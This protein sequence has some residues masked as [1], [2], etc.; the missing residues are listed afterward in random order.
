M[1]NQTWILEDL[2]I[3]Q[4][5]QKK[6]LYVGHV[7][8]QNGVKMELS[9]KLDAETCTK[10]ITILQEEIVASAVN[11]GDMLMKS[12]PIKLQ[13]PKETDSIEPTL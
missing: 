10:M 6:G 1:E 5:W 11:L 12:M 4:D 3:R 7:K 2:A 8:F 13:A 9:L